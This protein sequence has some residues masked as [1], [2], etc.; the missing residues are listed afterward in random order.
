MHLTK[1]LVA[2]TALL[3]GGVSAAPAPAGPAAPNYSGADISNGN[4]LKD[5]NKKA[6]DAAMAQIGKVSAR[7]GD[8]SCTTSN[9]KIRREWYVDIP[10]NLLQQAS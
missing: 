1:G 6:Y 8:S 3:A 4:A 7:A 9:I 5:L 10:L 2:A